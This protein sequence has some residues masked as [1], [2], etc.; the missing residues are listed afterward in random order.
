MAGFVFSQVLMT[1][2]RLGALDALR[3]GPL[4]AEELGARIGLPTDGAL[5]LMR[6]AAA[7]ELAEAVDADCFALGRLGA[8]MQANPSL[9]A[10][11]RHHGALYDDL[12]DAPALLRGEGA[13][14]RMARYWGYA[15]NAEA[16]AIS[17]EQA[18]EY[19]ELMAATQEMVSAEILGA[20]AMRGH[21]RLLD[22]GGGA[23][24]FVAAALERA[25]HL[26]AAVFDLPAV[27]EIAQ[28]RFAAAGLAGRADVVAGDFFRDPLPGG[29]DLI[30][31][32]RILHDHNDDAV[33]ALL[34][35]ARAATPPGGTVLVA[36]PMS[37]GAGAARVGDAYFGFYLMAM[38]TGRPRS[39][40]ELI[41]MLRSA[42]FSDATLKATHLPLVTRVIAAR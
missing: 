16:A 29:Y 42:G 34:R 26:E 38:G 9:Q 1:C 2:V 4:S 32:V 39:S 11:A 28:R 40:R 10:M 5:R 23:G 30:S 13:G 17:T 12:R 14:G 25:P 35:K 36:E 37:D 22:V 18:Q 33:M 19:T 7:L 6:A 21:R 27:T 3:A 24:V 20:Y 15:G 8:A 31:F 41:G